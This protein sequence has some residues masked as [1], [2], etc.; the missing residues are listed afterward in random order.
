MV[1]TLCFNLDLPQSAP[2]NTWKKVEVLEDFDYKLDKP[3]EQEEN[4][5]HAYQ[6]LKFNRNLMS[7]VGR[8]PLKPGEFCVLMLLSDCTDYP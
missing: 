4:L 7:M 3:S 1:S 5:D 8:S 6:K 2:N